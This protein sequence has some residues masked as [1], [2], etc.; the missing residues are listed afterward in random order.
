MK[1]ALVVAAVT[2]LTTPLAPG[3]SSD[4]LPE[5]VARATAQ[6]L[7]ETRAAVIAGEPMSTARSASV[8]VAASEQAVLDE[9]VQQRQ[10]PSQTRLANPRVALTY[11]DQ[12]KVA[13]GVVEVT[14]EQVDK[15]DFED[16]LGDPDP[17]FVFERYTRV[18]RFEVVDG[19]WQ[20][21]GSFATGTSM[22]PEMEPKSTFTAT[23]IEAPDSGNP[24]NA[25]IEAEASSVESPPS[26][27]RE[28]AASRSRTRFRDYALRHAENYNTSYKNMNGS[29][30]NPGGGDCTN[31]VSQ[32]LYHA[33]FAFWNF[34]KSKQS[35]GVWWYDN[36]GS[37][38]WSNSWTVAN[39]FY[40]FSRNSGR[41]TIV[42]SAN[43]L[44][45]GDVV[46]INFQP[47]R[48]STLDHTLAVTKK[49]SGVVYVSSHNAD[50]ANKRL[51]LVKDSYPDAW[52]SRLKFQYS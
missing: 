27:V 40:W 6:S 31:Y 38:S 25:E 47:A 11:E 16:E 50:Y 10:E 48:N 9:L 21:T 34:G 14:F 12:E 8:N 49:Q 41:A 2:G 43:D 1:T 30:W 28:L 23:Y 52:F 24:V 32:A 4:V 19:S 7:L 36:T 13:D 37:H 15:Y 3:Q 20:A 45:V 33:G 22:R 42:K 18:V 26:A 39:N 17:S 35:N 51:G 44:A 46:Q 5:S 29:W